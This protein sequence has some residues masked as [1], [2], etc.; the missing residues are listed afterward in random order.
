MVL[1]KVRQVQSVIAEV[2]L[3]VV[4]QHRRSKEDRHPEMVQ[5]RMGNGDDVHPHLD[6][7][8]GDQHHNDPWVLRVRNVAALA[9]TGRVVVAHTADGMGSGRTGRTIEDELRTHSEDSRDEVVQRGDIPDNP[10]GMAYPD[11]V[12]YGVACDGLVVAEEVLGDAGPSRSVEEREIR[13]CAGGLEDREKM[14]PK[15]VLVERG[16]GT[17]EE[18]AQEQVQPILAEEPPG[19]ELLVAFP[20]FVPG[21]LG[22]GL[23]A[24]DTVPVA[25]QQQQR[26]A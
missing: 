24:R 4:H 3:G 5:A 8:D 11:G 25:E 17:V 20:V 23:V 6:L 13:H 18:W 26:P 19:N 1:R 7:H 15:L 21:R 22:P 16:D 14:E 10:S 12:A 2:L 9:C